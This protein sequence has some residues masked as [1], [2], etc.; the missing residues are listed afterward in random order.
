[1]IYI[2]L[3]AIVLLS[4]FFIFN[5]KG[6][7]KYQ[8]NNTGRIIQR[9]YYDDIKPLLIIHILFLIP[10]FLI[11]RKAAFGFICGNIFSLFLVLIDIRVDYFVIQHYQDENKLYIK[12]IFESIK[13]LIYLFTNF[14]FYLLYLI[15]SNSIDYGMIFA[16]MIFS[17]FSVYICKAAKSKKII[18][19][20]NLSYFSVMIASSSLLFIKFA[21]INQI[22]LL[23]L[24]YTS[25]IFS[26]LINSLMKDKIA[27]IKNEAI[28]NNIIFII[29]YIIISL[30]AFT[31]H[32][33]DMIL[34]ISHILFFIVI[35]IFT[36]GKEKS[37]S[38]QTLKLF[39]LAVIIKFISRLFKSEGMDYHLFFGFLTASTL[40]VIFNY[41]K[42]VQF[43]F[44]LKIK[45]ID[46]DKE[47][48]FNLYSLKLSLLF[49]IILFYLSFIFA[50]D[51]MNRYY[52]YSD[53]FDAFVLMI[54]IGIFY[55]YELFGDKMIDIN[56]KLSLNLIFN[57]AFAVFCFSFLIV[58]I[59][60]ISTMGIT[61]LT[62]SILLFSFLTLFFSKTY[63]SYAISLLYLSSLY[64]IIY[65]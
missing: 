5:F 30:L 51:S 65:V 13:L 40:P 9:L 19:H 59:S 60:Y 54:P 18:N 38:Y 16:G 14:I 46:S 2:I 37:S 28:R 56:G 31:I 49:I 64:I 26:Y 58:A 63:Y 4:I 15:F 27:S 48:E 55:I 3:A 10:V 32:H 21:N 29:S 20:I 34:Y 7:N 33:I 22:K 57:I 53:I 61:N 41:L 39:I 62:T 17:A 36:I 42:T 11:S 44:I 25:F 35:Y 50:Y 45:D 43:N 24:I 52:G 47:L 23:I 1:M 12:N 8:K 6:I